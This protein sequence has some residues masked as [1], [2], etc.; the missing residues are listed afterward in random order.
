MIQTK[1]VK[2]VPQ[3]HGVSAQLSYNTAA[4]KVNLRVKTVRCAGG[5][6]VGLPPC[7]TRLTANRRTTRWLAVAYIRS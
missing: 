4:R 5:L 3:P 1:F 6:T 2:N 7:G